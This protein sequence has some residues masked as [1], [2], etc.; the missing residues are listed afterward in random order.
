MLPGTNSHLLAAGELKDVAQL[1]QLLPLAGWLPAA[2][3]Y[4]LLGWDVVA[5]CGM[6]LGKLQLA[7][8]VLEWHTVPHRI[9]LRMLLSCCAAK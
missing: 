9:L 2:I 6:N 4:F 5:H 1:K 8:V 3:K 7:A